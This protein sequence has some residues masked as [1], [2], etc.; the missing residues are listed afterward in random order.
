MESPVG[1]AR[2]LPLPGAENKE[3]NFAVAGCQAWEGGYYTAW[4]SI[5][6]EAFDFA[7]HY[8]DYIYEHRAVATDREN[9]PL[10][11]VMAEDFLACYTHTDYRRRYALYKTDPD[12]QAAHASCPFLASFDDHEV[13]GNWAAETDPRSTPA[14]AFLFRRAAAFQAWYERMPVRCSMVPRGPDVRAY[15]HLR[16]GALADIAVLDT[17]QYRSTQPCGD[18]LQGELPR[19]RR[20]W[21]HDAGRGAGALA[22]RSLELGPGDLAGAGATGAVLAAELA[23]FPVVAGA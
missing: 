3:L 11:R 17:R 5:A 14:D 6:E 18:G 7:F 22:G 1:R 10:P 19:G 21:P 12:L 2:T 9:R 13:A 8:G 20:T 15:R 16:F 23:V 4:R